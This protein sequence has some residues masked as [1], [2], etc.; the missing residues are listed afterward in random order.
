MYMV[1]GFGMER[2]ST[3]VRRRPP[4]PAPAVTPL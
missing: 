3:G 2:D 1:Q 4:V